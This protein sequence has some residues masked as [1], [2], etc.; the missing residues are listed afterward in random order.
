MPMINPQY[1]SHHK[2][3]HEPNAGPESIK[4]SDCVANY[5]PSNQVT[6]HGTKGPSGKWHSRKMECED[7][8]IRESE[9]PRRQLRLRVGKRESRIVFACDNHMQELSNSPIYT[10]GINGYCICGAKHVRHECVVY[11]TIC[12]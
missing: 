11:F 4:W 2:K 9:S 8:E 12:I 7:R 1:T 5:R 10:W 3:V 6:S